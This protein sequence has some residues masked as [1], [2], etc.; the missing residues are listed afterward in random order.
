MKGIA[1]NDQL[2]LLA[3]DQTGRSPSCIRQAGGLAQQSSRSRV[4]SAG[5]RREQELVVLSVEA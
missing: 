5:C 2:Q 3:D 1:E 4:G